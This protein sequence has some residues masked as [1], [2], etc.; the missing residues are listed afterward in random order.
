[1]FGHLPV[2]CEPKAVTSFI[3]KSFLSRCGIHL[4]CLDV[5]GVVHLLDDTAFGIISTYC[6]HLREVFTD[7]LIRNIRLF[8][9][10]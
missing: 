7:L 10:W 3:L 1:M 6:P 2:Q 9:E 8:S 4:R 5:S